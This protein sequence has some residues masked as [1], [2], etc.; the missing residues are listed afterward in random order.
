LSSGKV[1]NARLV[2]GADG[3]NSLVRQEANIPITRDSYDQHAL[4]ANVQLDSAHG[5]MTWQRFVPTGAQA[6]LPLADDRASLVWY[7]SA[8]EVARLVELADDEF[9]DE[10]S[11]TFP[12]EL[13]K[14]NTVLHR[15][16]FPL[17]KAH[18]E[19]YV[20][21]RIALIGDAAHTVHP[22]AGQG[23][24]LGM[25]DAAVLFDVI[26]DCIETFIERL[27]ISRNRLR[28]CA[29]RLCS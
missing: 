8:D 29:T 27:P 6:L 11:D 18:A 16:S 24:N 15:G 4:V 17:A 10:L 19:E 13:G 28:H 22:L 7:H 26:V 14:V 23:V 20:K 9:L 5:D 25:L 3:A 2:V 1:I 12:A 21:N